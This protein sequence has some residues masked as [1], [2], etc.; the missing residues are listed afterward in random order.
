MSD[1]SALARPDT[2]EAPPRCPMKFNV[3]SLLKEPTGAVRE[4][5][6]DE[7]VRIEGEP[8]RLRGTVRFDRTPEGV[9]VRAQL[10]GEAPA[11]CSRCLK[12]LVSPVY[13]S[14]GEQYLPT[15]DIVTGARVEPAEGEEDA[16]RIDQRHMLDL[17]EP[18]AQYW[19]MALPMAP[20][21]SEDCAGL[22]QECGADRTTGH[23]C[24]GEPVDA[25]WS[26]LRNLKL[27]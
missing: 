22:C 10:S 20:V 4:F 18:I 19:S 21:C 11:E 23:S 5:Q 16:Y 7:D 26:K 6:I 12:P 24:G 3:S 17:S 15:I 14:F 27:R 25:R 2:L 1:C 13:V 8:V 9:L